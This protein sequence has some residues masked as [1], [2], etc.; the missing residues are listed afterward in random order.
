MVGVQS[1]TLAGLILIVL[2]SVFFV[3]RGLHDE[4]VAVRSLD[5]KG[6]YGG[7]RCLLHGCNPY[8]E[9]D[10]RDSYAAAGGD[11][12]QWYHYGHNANYLPPAL[13]L[14]IPIAWLPWAPA[15]LV[16]LA[17]TAAA[18]VLGAILMWDLG[19]AYSPFLSA[20]LTSILLFTSTLILMTANPAG[21]AIGLCAISVWCFLR[22]RYAA[23]GVLCLAIS[24]LF[25]PHLTG[26][27]WLYFVLASA[28]HRK[29]AWQ[30][31]AV[32][33]ALSIPALAWVYLMPAS[34]HWVHDL[35]ANLVAINQPGQSSDPGPTNPDVMG[36]IDLQAIIAVFR[37]DP[38]FYNAVA[39]LI[40]AVLVVL[41]AVLGF[42]ASPSE[43]KDYFGL[44]ATAPIC[45]LPM[46][47]RYYD[48]RLLV[49]LIPALSLLIAKGPQVVRWVG[50]ILTAV[51]FVLT[52]HLVIS[53]M[54]FH[55]DTSTRL[56]QVKTAFLMRPLQM[57]TFVIA[58]FYL[59]AFYKEVSGF[60]L[61]REA[62]AQSQGT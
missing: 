60:G 47:H 6:V 30:T 33:A 19:R 37:D 51:G 46:Y 16:W 24:L 43:T 20:G 38:E 55:G 23:A 1:K 31:L 29:R 61:H 7:A 58:I 3:G 35:D 57:I 45:L 34:S 56:A 44:A 48:T 50:T 40:C 22:D 17:I 14:V 13:F 39:R 49:L 5:F 62:D 15:H 4:R 42:R 54:R 59:F 21:I 10:I 28:H 53:R 2:S 18:F 12:S 26:M 11:P 9:T 27:V 41:W 52:S 32:V 8:N 25:K 36:I